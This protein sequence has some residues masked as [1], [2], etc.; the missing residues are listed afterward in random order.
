MFNAKGDFVFLLLKKQK[1]YILIRNFDIF[2][3]YVRPRLFM[4]EYSFN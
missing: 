2:N 1:K 3:I 4:P